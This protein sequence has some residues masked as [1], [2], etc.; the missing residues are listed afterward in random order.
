M[1]TRLFMH[2]SHAKPRTAFQRFLK[3]IRARL[4][5]F[6]RHVKHRQL[7]A[8]SN[9]DAHRVGNHGVLASQHTANRQAIADVGV[10][11]QRRPGGH[12]RAASLPHLRVAGVVD[13]GAPGAIADRRRPHKVSL[14]DHVPGKLA[15]T[16]I[17]EVNLG[18]LQDTL[19]AASHLLAA[20]F[21][22]LGGQLG[23]LDSAGHAVG[24]HAE[25]LKLSRVHSL[26]RRIVL[27]A[28]DGGDISV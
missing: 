16:R 3:Q 4:Q 5:R 12:R 10:R 19:H 8:A 7:H 24:R 6:D 20:H 25:R 11:H 15:E 1:R 9:V 23:S 27:V 18:M 14:R 21:F 13:L 22:V 2:D 26:S 28:A 17:V